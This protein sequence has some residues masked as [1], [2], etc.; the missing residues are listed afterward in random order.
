MIAAGFIF[1]P[2][3]GHIY[4]KNTKRFLVGSGIRFSAVLLFL[5]GLN[6]VDPGNSGGVT[7]L[8]ILVG[9]ALGAFGMFRDFTAVDNS[10]REYNDNLNSYNYN[11]NPAIYTQNDNLTFGLQF[12]ITK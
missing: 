11:L 3:L 12:R 1:C 4:A 9:M 7:D 2:G 8:G 6:R 5:Y 10:V